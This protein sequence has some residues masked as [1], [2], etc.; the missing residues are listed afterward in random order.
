MHEIGM[1][2]GLM[3]LMFVFG[4]IISSGIVFATENDTS[5]ESVDKA[6]Q[7]LKGEIDKRASLSFQEAVFSTLA[8]GSYKGNLKVIDN[9]KHGSQNCW[10]KSGCKIKETGQ[11]LLALSRA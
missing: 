5:G 6:Y 8:L 4:L 7:C 10:P 11:A 9:E 2:K 3:S 1:R